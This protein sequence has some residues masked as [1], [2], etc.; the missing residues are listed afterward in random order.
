MV[1]AIKIRQSSTEYSSVSTCVGIPICR[2]GTE[3]MVCSPKF[4]TSVDRRNVVRCFCR[5][6]G[7]RFFQGSDELGQ[8]AAL[9]QGES[10]M[11]DLISNNEYRDWIGSIK[12]RVQTSQ[13]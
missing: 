13:I 12:H 6:Y 10:K 8:G 5:N 1:R 2:D 11:T 4:G 7:V 3:R 9:S